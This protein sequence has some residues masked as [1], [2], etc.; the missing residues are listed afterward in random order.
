MQRR[1]SDMKAPSRNAVQMPEGLGAT[2]AAVASA[3]GV[4]AAPKQ[5]SLARVGHFGNAL[6]SAPI[7]LKKRELPFEAHR[8][9]RET[10]RQQR[11]RE[12]LQA[13]GGLRAPWK[14]VRS[15]KI[16]QE[17]GATVGAVI[18]ML[19]DDRPEVIDWLVDGGAEGRAKFGKFAE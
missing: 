13:P 18:D 3:S 9:T 17:T 12:N 14:Y 7:S 10:K 16:A 2:K 15:S 6:T 19:L 5:M 8:D 1:R 4:P 11:D